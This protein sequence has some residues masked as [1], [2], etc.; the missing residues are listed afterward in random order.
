MLMLHGLHRLSVIV[1][2]LMYAAGK[3]KPK[4]VALSLVGDGGVCRV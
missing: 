3:M 4:M 1:P 2:F